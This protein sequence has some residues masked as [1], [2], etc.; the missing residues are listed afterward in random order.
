M[1]RKPIAPP[2]PPRL[3]NPPTSRGLRIQDAAA[4]SGLSPFYVEEL[5]RNGRLLSIGGPGSGV[6]VA[7]IVLREHVDELLDELAVDAKVRAAK[8]RKVAA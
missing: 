2:S 3:V 1:T 7:H 4:Y 6:C 8:K 5:I